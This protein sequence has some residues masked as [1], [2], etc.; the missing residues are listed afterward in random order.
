MPPSTHTSA[1]GSLGP[2][3]H[4][5]IFPGEL[6]ILCDLVQILPTMYNLSWPLHV[7]LASLPFSAPI[8]PSPFLYFPPVMMCFCFAL[9]CF[10]Y[11]SFCDQSFLS[12]FSPPEVSFLFSPGPA[13]KD[14]STT[15]THKHTHCNLGSTEDYQRGP[16]EDFHHAL[17]SRDL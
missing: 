12:P 17:W 1:W 2:R 16:K 11:G 8:M 15:H 7:K 4:P 9:S 3:S 13:L 6:P 10:I 5:T 14:R